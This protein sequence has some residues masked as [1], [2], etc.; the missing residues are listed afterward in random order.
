MSGEPPSHMR[1][2]RHSAPS[3]PYVESEVIEA[4]TALA[5]TD[6][7]HLVCVYCRA[8]ATNSGITLSISLR[9]GNPM[10]TGTNSVTWFH[11][12]AHVTQAKGV[13]TSAN[14]CDH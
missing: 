1:S 8:E 3:D 4:L 5:Q 9:M 14:L 7:D 12:A 6:L 13:R 10:D 2:P 11:A